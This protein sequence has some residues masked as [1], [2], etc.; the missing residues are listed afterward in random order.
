[1][2]VSGGVG[3]ANV[4]VRGTE[5]LVVTVALSLADSTSV[6]DEELHHVFTNLSC[7]LLVYM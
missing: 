4:G 2:L 7:I 3:I 5:P 6:A 1:M